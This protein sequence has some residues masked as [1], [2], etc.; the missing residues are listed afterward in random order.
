MLSKQILTLD[1]EALKQS[2]AQFHYNKVTV[3]SLVKSVELY[4]CTTIET[5]PEQAKI[6][7]IENS[8]FTEKGD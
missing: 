4:V 1:Y 8:K 2:E 3:C 5:E 7:V 6:T